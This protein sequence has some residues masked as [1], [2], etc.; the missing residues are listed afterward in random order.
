MSPARQR[1]TSRSTR[2]WD[3]FWGAVVSIGGLSVIVAVLGIFLY[4]VV[5]VIPLF[6]PGRVADPEPSTLATAA[7]PIALLTDEYLG[8][9]AAYHA[10][11]TLQL[12]HI[13]TRT[14]LGRTSLASS[15]GLA[16]AAGSSSPT[17][18]ALSWDHATGLIAVGFSDGSIR[19]GSL[20]FASE[21]FRADDSAA[22]PPSS[23]D[24]IP[25]PAPSPSLASV[26]AWPGE[27]H[28]IAPDAWR[29]TRPAFELREP[30]TPKVG[31]GSPSPVVA[32]DYRRRA[33][34][35]LLVVLRAD[36]SAE[37]DHVRTVRPLGGGKPRVRLTTFPVPFQRP[38]DRQQPLLALATSDGGSILFLW[39]DGFIQRYACANPE[40][41]P[42]T[43]AESFS[44]LPQGRSVTSTAA[45]LGGLTLLIGDDS[46]H[47]SGVFS[48][49]D[50]AAPTADH[51]RLVRAA[52]FRASDL[53]ITR[54]AL[55]PRDR[56]FLA[57]DDHGR[58]VVINATSGKIVASSD[59]LPSAPAAVA[60]APKM[61]ALVTLDAAGTLTRIPLD[62]GHPE[63]STS[64]LFAPVWYEG[65][66]KPAHV[67]QSSS[68]DDA[69]E[70]KFGLVALIVGTLKATVFSMLFA[71]PI[72]VLAAIYTSEF[73]HPKV[74][75]KV[76]PVIELMASVPS[77]VLGFIAAVI[78]APFL[79]DRVPMLLAAFAVVPA[80]VLIAAHL[81]QAVP[82]RAAARA[83]TLGRLIL[84][85]LAVVLGVFLSA[86]IGPR[87]ESILFSPTIAD[88]LVIAG[89]VE[90]ALE[91]ERPAW[92]GGRDSLSPDDQ[93]RLRASN[94]FLRDG[95]LVRPA[96]VSKQQ[97]AAINADLAARG[98]AR[99]SFL[100]WLDGNIGGPRPGWIIV[101]ILPAAA[102]AFAAQSRLMGR[103]LNQ[104]FSRLPRLAAAAAD[105]ARA[106]ASMV[107][108]VLL[109]LLLAQALT[110]LGLDP[111]DVVF[112][113]YSQRNTLVV[114]LIM[115]FA[116]I[117]IIYTI[118]ED[119]LSSVPAS[120]RS[121]SLGAGATPWQTAVR[122]VLPVAASGIFSAA[123]IGLGRAVGETMIV[124]MATGNTPSMDWNIFSGFRTLSAN[125]AVELPEAPKDSTHYRIL[126]LCGLVLFAMTFAIN[127]T[128]EICRQYYRRRNAAL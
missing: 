11:G 52:L 15:T 86:V 80:T 76:K 53:P 23:S 105:L 82:S 33:D 106:L 66:P 3:R 102:I 88:R 126:F 1:P 18:S 29:I 54:L 43:L 67:Y 58:L 84:V 62:P 64:A 36:G 96:P 19:L 31:A 63:A 112:G 61:D 89:H 10:D 37:L 57:A 44:T 97:L 17:P 81:W 14:L 41:Q 74:R 123:M 25:W 60:I 7:T 99:P 59:A 111:R 49:Y 118:A 40:A 92:L 107:A 12:H 8:L 128:A 6:E 100:Q 75:G 104:R 95:R 30:I 16:P 24:R 93:R 2:F 108:A 9:A 13:P 48:A 113:P 79:R 77:V 83:G 26:D 4:L 73:L 42:I 21:T 65:L 125:I 20:T 47:V 45:L 56:S 69:A 34:L 50:P 72:A 114:G 55:S 87:A 94:L 109:A 117:P 35:E 85:S 71:L 38:A 103:Q 28:R 46:G 22:P 116:V 121:A 101:M 119:A 78:V 127:T 124:V 51:Q 122:V 91:S 98:L 110:R 70:P 5:T 32:I 39:R 115:G 120:L 68:G 27:A 90:P